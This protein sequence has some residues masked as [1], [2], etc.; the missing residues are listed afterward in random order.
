MPVAT[1]AG[2]D[3]DDDDDDDGDDDAGT[4]G[5]GDAEAIEPKQL[6]EEEEH[7]EGQE[8]KPTASTVCSSL[9]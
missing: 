7:G 1:T 4:G 6:G 2:D 9:R 3:D 5:N 8:E